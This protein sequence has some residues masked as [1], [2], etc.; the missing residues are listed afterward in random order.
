MRKKSQLVGLIRWL[1]LAPLMACA[2]ADPAPEI[3]AWWVDAFHPGFKSPEEIRVLVKEARAAHLNTLLVQ[4]RKRGDAYYQSQ[5]VPR[6]EDI[7]VGFDP[8]LEL[9]RQTRS[10]S[11]R[12]EVHAW[13]VLYP[14]W[15][16]RTNLPS[17][18]DHVFRAHPEWL[19]CDTNHLTWDG[20]NHALDPGHPGVQQHLR[21]VIMELAANYPVD[22][23]HLDYARY[24][25]R[26]WGYNS[27]SLERFRKRFGRTEDPVPD[28]PDWCQF[29][30]DQ[31]TS[32]VRRL[33]L[34]LAELRPEIKLSA[35]TIC[36]APGPASTSEWTK[37]AAYGD[38]FQ[39][40][41]AWLEEG[42]LDLNVPMAY[43]AQ[44]PHGE[45]WRRWSAFA[46]LQRYDRQMA[47][48]LG[49][50]TNSLEGTVVQIRSARRPFGPAAGADGFSLYSYHQS[51]LKPMKRSDWIQRLTRSKGAAVAPV[52]ASVVDVPPMPWKGSRSIGLLRGEVMD[53]GSTNAVDGLHVIL[54]GPAER[55][56]HTDA[57]GYFGFAKLPPGSYEVRVESPSGDLGHGKAEV[58]GGRVATVHWNLPPT[59][60]QEQQP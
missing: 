17:S 15:N 60:S 16:S 46:K 35:A 59:H 38:K 32:M 42:I 11:P 50:Y 29:R 18:P 7:A 12:L 28:D 27:A 4:V 25:R 49:A 55:S 43:F 6:A 45:A 19:S 36:F 23:I 58:L 8:L 13:M 48:G 51:S 21:E 26:E 30:R 22:G 20:S 2:L 3:R 39:D 33:Y 1:C 53:L 5:R 40:W 52:L 37:S 14:I 54:R 47:L 56:T 10:G 44:A 31:V 9:L 24:S 57:A 34:S 41:R